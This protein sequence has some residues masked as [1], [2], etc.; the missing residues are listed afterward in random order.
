MLQLCDKL[1]SPMGE[2]AVDC[3]SLSSM[4][5]ISFTIGGKVFDL[6]PEQVK[7]HESNS[8]ACGYAVSLGNSY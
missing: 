3:G 4:P 6:A 7:M 1:P 2:S 8:L 5:S